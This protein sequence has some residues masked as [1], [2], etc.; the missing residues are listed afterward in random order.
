[1]LEYDLTGDIQLTL[2]AYHDDDS[3]ASV[4]SRNIEE[5]PESTAPFVNYYVVNNAGSN[6]TASDP[7]KV[8]A[9][10]L[11]DESNITQGAALDIEWELG[12]TLFRSLS[13]YNDSEVIYQ[14]LD[15]DGSDVVTFSDISGNTGYETFSQEFQL[16]SNNEGSLQWILGLFYYT[17]D[18]SYIED[19]NVDNLFVVGGPNDLFTIESD[20][21]AQSLGVF[22]QLEYSITDKW[23]VIA[24]LRYSKDEKTMFSTFSFPAFGIVGPNGEPVIFVDDN[25]EWTQVTGKLG[26]NYHINE[27]VM[28]YTS[29]STGY[30]SGGYNV[31]QATPYDEENVKAYE[32]G[33]KSL[34]SDGKVQ[35]NI[36]AFYYDYT[37]K[38][39]LGRT[40]QGFAEILNAGEATVWGVELE[41]SARPIPSLSIDASVGYLNT[42]YDEF[43]SIDN[44]LNPALGFQDLAGNELVHAPEWK[45]S[46]GL[47]YEWALGETGRIVAR[48]DTSWVDEQ[49]SR[50]FNQAKDQV[51]SYHRTNVQVR[52]D[53]Q[54][55]LWQAALSAQNLTDEDTIDNQVPV[56]GGDI[57]I[58]TY[59]P[60][61]TYGL[62][63]TRR[64]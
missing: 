22:G 21:E 7:W 3:G 25:E 32:L 14:H 18:S 39:E 11:R 43:I 34:W 26:V 24:G 47:Q 35:T 2:S 9:S 53:S 13:A 51:D 50:P 27:D 30:K 28:L 57:L 61:R 41:A 42:E 23:E 60:P 15:G 58:A 49:F 46:L 8:R 31:L 4:A 29:Y 56:L 19:H 5:F 20:V 52:W 12:N 33:L 48:V 63:I 55:E 37:D 6:I 64:F 36:S 44:V 40:T 1:M 62:R 10:D 54:D 16:L 38:Q 45:L 17:E 59:L